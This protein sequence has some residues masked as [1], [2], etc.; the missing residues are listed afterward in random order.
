[1]HGMRCSRPVRQAC[2]SGDTV[3]GTPDLV[4][5]ALL[6]IGGHRAPDGAIAQAVRAMRSLNCPTLAIDVPTGLDADTGRPLGVDAV[7]AT[8]TLSLLTLKPGLFTGAGRDHAGTVWLDDLGVDTFAELPTAWLA[9]LDR[10]AA[11]VS[12]D[13]A[14]HKGSYAD[15]V[16]LGGA[17]GMTGAALLA[18]RAASAAG[19]GRVFVD[20]LD[21]GSIGHDPLRPELMFRLGWLAANRSGLATVVCGCGG[22]DAVREVL[23][24][25]IARAA[26]LVLDADALNAIARDPAL[27]AQLQAR[28]T[29]GVGTVLTPH[30]LE[31][32]RLLGCTAAEVQADRLAAAAR[33]AEHTRAVVVLKGSGSIVCATGRT[34]IVNPTGNASLATA[35]TGDVLAG[36]LGGSWL[37]D[38]FD[39]A[40][41]AVL[42]HGLAADRAALR[43]C[44]PPT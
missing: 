5:D 42:L 22:G 44:A 1:M 23:P 29:R 31:A 7:H 15:L 28:A 40:A 24:L 4:I 10:H 43:C 14:S 21:G 26:R 41:A 32:A 17:P 2:R 11:R 34:P 18:A 33:L 3:S 39:A 9:G 13:H 38:A 8:H 37:H 6:G 27:L 19:A 35:G 25:A 30:P 36:W 20:L 16:V 12:R